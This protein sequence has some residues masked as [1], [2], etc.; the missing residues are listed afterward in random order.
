M[1]Y[2]IGH[3]LLP[4]TVFL[5]QQFSCILFY[6][7]F[8]LSLSFCF[9]PSQSFSEDKSECTRDESS[10][11]VGWQIAHD[12]YG[13]LCTGS[14]GM[15]SMSEVL[16]RPE[17]TD[18]FTMVVVVVVF[19]G[20]VDATVKGMECPMSN[21]LYF[22]LFCGFLLLFLPNSLSLARVKRLKFLCSWVSFFSSFYL[23]IFFLREE[24]GFTCL[25]QGL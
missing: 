10:T 3:F 13:S 12:L 21:I 6:D 7:L 25:L 24:K 19:V 22:L 17:G 16:G 11:G 20:H 8:I 23:A 15:D 14:L 18:R 2:I 1:I 5:L 4:S 9:V